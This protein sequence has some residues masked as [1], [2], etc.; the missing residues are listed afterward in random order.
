MPAVVV[1]IARAPDACWRAF[2][3]AT[4]FAEWMPDLH[5]ADVISTNESGLPHEVHF[6]FSASLSYSLVYDYDLEAREVRWEPHVGKLDAVRGSARIEP[7]GD[8]ARI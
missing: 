4:L 1:D 3:D 8:G 7:H 6:E 2:T 5:R